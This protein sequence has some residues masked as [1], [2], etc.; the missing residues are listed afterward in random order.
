MVWTFL[1]ADNKCYHTDKTAIFFA[2]ETDENPGLIEA[3]GYVMG[4][5]NSSACDGCYE[6]NWG[7]CGRKDIEKSAMKNCAICDQPENR[8]EYPC[9]LEFGC[10]CGGD[11]TWP[12]PNPSDGPGGDDDGDGG[13]G[14]DDWNPDDGGDGDGGDDWNPDDGGD[15]WNPDDWGALT[16]SGQVAV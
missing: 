13:D 12:I 2:N 8:F 10:E 3:P 9:F 4:V 6:N 7:P 1:E 16:H 15:D 5:K 11:P 14:G